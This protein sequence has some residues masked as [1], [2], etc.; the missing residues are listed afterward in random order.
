MT[1]RV[2]LSTRILCIGFAVRRSRLRLSVIPQ[3][4]VGSINLNT[5]QI[6]AFQLIEQGKITLDTP[7][8][9]VLPELANPVVVS[10]KDDA[11]NP[12]TAPATGK[13]TFGQL[14]NHTSGIDSASAS[15]KAYGQSRGIL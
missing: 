10:G 12:L 7:A 1:L 9:S 6:A 3:L 13:I 15:K 14:L 11:G 8:E 2:I 4:G 5:T